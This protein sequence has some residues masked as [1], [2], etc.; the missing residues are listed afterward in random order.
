MN[1][2][3][4]FTKFS[5]ADQPPLRTRVLSL[6]LSRRAR[7][8]TARLRDPRRL[9]GGGVREMIAGS[10]CI[11]AALVIFADITK[12][13]FRARTHLHGNFTRCAIVI[14]FIPFRRH[15]PRFKR[16]T[17]YYGLLKDVSRNGS[18]VVLP[19]PLLCRSTIITFSLFLHGRA[20]CS[21]RR[22]HSAI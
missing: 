6:S 21:A 17:R 15:K 4:V 3:Y 8:E 16:R 2:A 7:P 5:C 11:R 19:R 12:A 22:N 13:E 14:G 18:S 1:F 20:P 9:C 10:G